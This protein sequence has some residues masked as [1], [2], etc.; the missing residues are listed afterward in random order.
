MRL[1]S[2]GSDSLEVHCRDLGMERGAMLWAQ[3]LLFVYSQL[4]AH[5][6]DSIFVPN[7]AKFQTNSRKATFKI[8]PMAKWTLYSGSTENIIKFKN[9]R[10]DLVFFYFHILVNPSKKREKERKWLI[11][12]LLYLNDFLIRNSKQ[13]LRVSD[14]L[15]YICLISKKIFLLLST[16]FINSPGPY[17][18]SQYI[19]TFPQEHELVLKV[20]GL[21]STADLLPY[22]VIFLC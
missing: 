7:M 3:P 22:F 15:K 12:C 20:P 2:Q 9:E 16:K 21:N 4:R 13:V 17:L 18:F 6:Q 1:N 11:S 19:I 14:Y 5:F 8:Y 10:K